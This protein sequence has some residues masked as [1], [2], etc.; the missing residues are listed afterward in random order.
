MRY[1]VYFLHISII[2][3]RCKQILGILP[4]NDTIQLVVISNRPR[5][6]IIFLLKMQ[7]NWTIL[8][9]TASRL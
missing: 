1:Q 5:P 7:R 9:I 2:F 4:L 8:K 3:K 6:I